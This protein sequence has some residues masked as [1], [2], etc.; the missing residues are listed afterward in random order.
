MT[1]KI[2]SN[3][4]EYIN[5]FSNVE[6]LFNIMKMEENQE[7]FKKNYQIE[8]GIRKVY[9]KEGCMYS[10]EIKN[11]KLEGKGTLLIPFK[12]FEKLFPDSKL[13]EVKVNKMLVSIF[14]IGEFKNNLMHGDGKITNFYGTTYEGKFEYGLKNGYGVFIH[15]YNSFYRGYWKNGL[16][17]GKGMLKLND[18]ITDGEWS[19]D[20]FIL[21]KKSK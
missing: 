17:H 15:Q 3:E 10:G 21:K 14:Y 18:K 1:I 13:F 2:V 5:N 4:N 12:I 11:G 9:L 20:K 8:D 6:S 19:N 7:N 16:K